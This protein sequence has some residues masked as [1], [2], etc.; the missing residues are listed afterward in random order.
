MRAELGLLAE[1]DKRFLD[2]IGG[3]A[4]ATQFREAAEAASAEPCPFCGGRPAA[5]VSSLLN[6]LAVKVYC[7][8]CGAGTKAY[9]AGP[10]IVGESFTIMGSL[11]RAIEDWNRRTP[12]PG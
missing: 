5:R 9:I 12:A 6:R 10:T 8:E 11:E 2:M 7:Q 4:G 1:N 3:S